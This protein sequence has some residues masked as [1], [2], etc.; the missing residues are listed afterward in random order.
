MVERE[1]RK[2]RKKGLG[3][4]LLMGLVMVV[5]IYFVDRYGFKNVSAGNT[6]TTDDAINGVMLQGFEWFLEDYGRQEENGKNVETL[7]EFYSNN[8][9]QLADKGFTAI[10]LPPAFKTDSSNETMSQGYEPYD[11]YDLGEFYQKGRT[12][13]KYGS[14]EQYLNAIKSLQAVGIN[15]YA[16]IILGHK[17]GGDEAEQVNAYDVNENY[18]DQYSNL[19][20]MTAYTKF[21]YPGRN[22]KYSTFVWDKTCFDAFSDNNNNIFLIEGQSWDNVV[23]EDKNNMDYLMFLDVDLENQNVVDELTNWGKWYIDQTGVD[24]FR[25]DAVKH[26]DYEFLKKWLI[27]MKEYSDK[28][29]YVFSEYYSGNTTSLQAYLGYTDYETSLYDFKLFFNFYE[30]GLEDSEYNLANLFKG[31]LV[32]KSPFHAV[33]FVNN[34]DQQ[35]GRDT[36]EN[37]GDNK[38]VSEEFKPQ[39]Y[40]SI[41]T[42]EEGYPCVFYGDY[43]GTRYEASMQKTIDKLMYIRKNYAYGEQIDYNTGTQSNNCIG[44]VRLGDSEHENSGLAALISDNDGSDSEYSMNMYVGKEHAGEMWYDHLGNYPGIITINNLGYGE[45]MCNSNSCSVWIPVDT[46]TG[47]NNSLVLYYESTWENNYIHYQIGSGAW[48]VVP[49][50]KMQSTNLDNYYKA[51]I[52]MGSESLV[53]FCLNDGNGQWNNNNYEDFILTTGTYT[54]IGCDVKSG[55][56]EGVVADNL[57]EATIQPTETPIESTV[58]PDATQEPVDIVE[59]TEVPKYDEPTITSE[60]EATE[61]PTATIE[62]EATDEPDNIVTI[63]YYS[64]WEQCNIHYKLGNNSWTD[65]PGVAMSRYDSSYYVKQIE[66]DSTNQII[67]CFNNNN[68]SWDSKNGANYTISGAGNFIVKNGNVSKGQP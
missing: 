14:R 41:L 40:T 16:D 60:P 62:P 39:A 37:D 56:P 55:I 17:T 20:S 64:G 35:E 53:R 18:R 21:T 7:W 4:V 34:H 36:I 27:D 33:T 13:T 44:W 31:T 50:V 32:S 15:V 58:V 1:I 30:A 12:N 68:N 9:K 49:G 10:W 59:P 57:P 47:D 43:Y 63:Y 42:R 22:G 26:M 61:V 48:T 46:I 38:T 5:G 54:I 65:V 28:D 24:G 3:I 29:L 6:S 66:L 8:A 2:K 25:V 23:Y 11:L 19:S 52:D 45:F 67:V 51:E